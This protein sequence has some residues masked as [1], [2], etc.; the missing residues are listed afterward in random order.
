MSRKPAGLPFS[1]D[2]LAP[3]FVMAKP[4]QKVSRDIIRNLEAAGNLINTRKRDGYRHYI[5]K[6]NSAVKIY[7]R[8][9]E[10]VTAKYPHIV[11]EVSWMELPSWTMLDTEIVFVD[12][13]GNDDI[14]KFTR[15]VKSNSAAAIKLQ[16][17][18]G[19]AVCIV[20]G[21][22]VFGGR[23]VTVLPH[24]ER[25][26]L[27]KNLFAKLDFRT[28]YVEPVEILDCLFEKARA[29]VKKKRWEGLV[30]YDKIK[31]TAFGLDGKTASPIRLDGCWKWKP[32]KEDDFIVRTWQKG[33]GR[34]KNRAGKLFL[35][36]TD[37]RTGKEVSC[38]EV[39]N[40]TDKMREYFAKEARY[41]LVVQMEFEKRF[42]SGALR[43]VKFMRIREDK[44]PEECLLPVETER[45]EE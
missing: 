21:V 31:P 34:N 37:S 20:F 28:Y 33:T 22:I 45:G 15:I 3:N 41:P 19:F 11:Q 26:N 40:L 35:L 44:R 14:E 29:I 18:T 43:N 32:L 39:G 6:S 24:Q 27:V 10:D 12:E 30:L 5:V 23:V 8:G 2:P 25:F 38:G 42:T 17:E 16:E 36:Q 9:I 1:L 7:T 13:N 4:R